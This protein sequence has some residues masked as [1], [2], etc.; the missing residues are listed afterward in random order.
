MSTKIPYGLR[1]SSSHYDDVFDFADQVRVATN[2]VFL[3]AAAEY[4]ADV[5]IRNMDLHRTGDTPAASHSPLDAVRVAMTDKTM[6]RD[7]LGGPLRVYPLP[8]GDFLGYLMGGNAQYLEA[9]LAMPGVTEYGYWNNTDCYPDGVT[10]ADWEVRKA[11]WESALTSGYFSR[12]GIAIDLLGTDD[13][14]IRRYDEAVLE[15]L[16]AAQPSVNS[17]A[18]RILEADRN[19]TG[20]LLPN[21]NATTDMW[22]VV[23]AARA[24][25]QLSDPAQYVKGLK[26]AA[27]PDFHST[28]KTD[29]VRYE[30]DAG[31]ALKALPK[32]V[33]GDA[34]YNNRIA[35][36]QEDPEEY[37]RQYP[38]VKCPAAE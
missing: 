34:L 9:L 26:P 14:M 11:T 21:F 10:E 23:A 13:F 20:A 27:A 17:R 28:Y 12:H 19:I 15:A 24:V 6:Y 33:A 31:A 36:L 16:V 29:A 3:P 22:R 1:I 25:A 38:L 37:F 5:A 8:D 30:V 35:L 4:V 7:R 18:I 2:A 32:V